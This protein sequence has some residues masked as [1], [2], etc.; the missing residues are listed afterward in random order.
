MHRFPPFFH[1][2]F[3]CELDIY[4]PITLTVRPGGKEAGD[5]AKTRGTRSVRE[6]QVHKGGGGGESGHTYT[7]EGGDTFRGGGGHT[8]RRG[9]SSDENYSKQNTGGVSIYHVRQKILPQQGPKVAMVDTSI[10]FPREN[11]AGGKEYFFVKKNL[12]QGSVVFEH[13]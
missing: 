13:V 5:P 6:T 11:F 12:A 8:F 10:R 2:F 3:S 7:G 4:R 1:L 9:V